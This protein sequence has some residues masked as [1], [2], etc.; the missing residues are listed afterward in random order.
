M[1]KA[2]LVSLLIAL[3]FGIGMS[4]DTPI[5][6]DPDT[7]EPIQELPEFMGDPS[8][9][10]GQNYDR[11]TI[12]L[13]NR[14]FRG[15]TFIK[16]GV[17]TQIGFMNSNLINELKTADSATELAEVAQND[18]LLS[19][20]GI[21]GMIGSLFLFDIDG[22]PTLGLTLYTGSFFLALIKQYSAHNHLQ[23]AIWLYNREK[24]LEPKP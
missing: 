17:E 20:L 13:Q 14:F 16:G 12:Y 10:Y 21:G 11:N 2:A 4:Q 19:M 15:V 5:Q 9:V 3:C 24:T 22:D 1:K 23:K 18:M 7:G 6:Y 8:Q